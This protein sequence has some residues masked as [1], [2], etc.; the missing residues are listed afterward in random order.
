M[1]TKRRE[2]RNVSQLSTVAGLVVLDGLVS[3]APSSV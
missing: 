1:Q 3:K 2:M